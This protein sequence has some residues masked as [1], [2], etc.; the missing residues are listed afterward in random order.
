[1]CDKDNKIAYKPGT[2][3][4]S[5]LGTRDI[6][7][8][9][10]ESFRTTPLITVHCF[11]DNFS[12]PAHNQCMNHNQICGALLFTVHCPLTAKNSIFSSPPLP[13]PTHKQRVNFTAGEK[14]QLLFSQN[15]PLRTRNKSVNRLG[16][17]NI[18][19]Q[20]GQTKGETQAREFRQ[21][22][23]ISFLRWVRR[24]LIPDP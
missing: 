16:I 4:P 2:P 18:T 6:T 17:N 12:L 24:P 14:M 20:Q 11:A 9:M 13:Q 22:P 8:P 15:W 19:N 21:V 1:L 3:D 7:N 10:R 23:Q 5:H